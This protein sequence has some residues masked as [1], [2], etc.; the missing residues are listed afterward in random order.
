M[1]NIFSKIRY[2]GSIIE[3]IYIYILN[4]LFHENLLKTKQNKTCM[5]GKSDCGKR[6]AGYN[7]KHRNKSD[8]TQLL[9][10]P[11]LKFYKF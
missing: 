3:Y 2:S 10:T 7:E 6:N 11:N 1:Q 4:A 9:S 8:S 5:H